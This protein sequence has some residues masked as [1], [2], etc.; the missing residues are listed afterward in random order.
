MQSLLVL[1]RNYHIQFLKN[2]V[3]KKNPLTAAATFAV[4]GF[5]MLYSAD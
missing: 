3:Q 2:Y 4:K 5:Y 1:A